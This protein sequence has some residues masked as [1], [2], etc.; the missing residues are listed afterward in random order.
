MTDTTQI[1]V[2]F[3]EPLDGGGSVLTIPLIDMQNLPDIMGDD[4]G[5]FRITLGTCTER[6]MESAGEWDGF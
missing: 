3:I 1:P 5:P 2:A 4:R 6:E